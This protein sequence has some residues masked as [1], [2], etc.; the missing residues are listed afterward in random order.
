MADTLLEGRLKW[1]VAGDY[2]ENVF[3]WECTAAGVNDYILS[4]R[5]AAA[6]LAVAGP[7]TWMTTLLAMIVDVV[8]VSTIQTRVIKPT[9]GSRYAQGLQTDARI[10]TVS[11][12]LYTDETAYVLNWLSLTEPTKMGRNYIAGIPATYTEAGRFT[13]AAQTAANAFMNKHVAGLA[14]GGTNFTPVIYRASAGTWRT[15][16]DGFLGPN[17]GQ[18]SQRGIGE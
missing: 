13:N 10:G 3:H 14:N 2:A 17:I 16:A 7:P 15:I 18:M 11:D 6:M 12:N 9:G 1:R 5:L 8:F 4:T